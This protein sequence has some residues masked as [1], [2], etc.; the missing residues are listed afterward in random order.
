MCTITH[1]ILNVVIVIKKAKGVM[2]SCSG[3]GNRFMFFV[4]FHEYSWVFAKN[5]GNFTAFCLFVCLFVLL[6]SSLAS[7]LTENAV[8]TR[9]SLKIKNLSF[10]LYGPL[11]CV[12]V[13]QVFPRLNSQSFPVFPVVWAEERL[14]IQSKL[15]WLHVVNIEISTC[16]VAAE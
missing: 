15:V 6:A 11:F 4:L 3:H 2:V 14:R 16:Y 9:C 12:C 10:R 1:F 7:P 8:P 13:F 5:A